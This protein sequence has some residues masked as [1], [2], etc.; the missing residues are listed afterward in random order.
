MCALIKGVLIEAATCP[1][2][3]ARDGPEARIVAD[4]INRKLAPHNHLFE[5][6]LAV[7]GGYR[8]A[9]NCER[10]RM[11]SNLTEMKVRRELT[12][13]LNFWMVAA[14]GIIAQP[15]ANKSTEC[16]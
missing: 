4:K 15:V 3:D 2:L 6:R 14:V 8:C 7:A 10:H 12:G 16:D 1:R 5:K 9:I 11:R 13:C